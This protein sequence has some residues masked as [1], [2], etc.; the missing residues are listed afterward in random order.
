MIRIDLELACEL[1]G[2]PPTRRQNRKWDKKRGI[3][4][5]A[6]HG[7]VVVLEGELDPKARL[8]DVNAQLATMGTYNV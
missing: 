5:R 2:L 8:A 3:A 7:S 4:Y 1:I 6:T